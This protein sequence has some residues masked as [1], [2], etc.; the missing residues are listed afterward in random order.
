MP[1]PFER[2]RDRDSHIRNGFH[3]FLF[4]RVD[5]SWRMGS[6]SLRHHPIGKSCRISLERS[7]D[8]TGELLRNRQISS[9]CRSAKPA[10]A[11]SNCTACT[12]SAFCSGNSLNRIAP[13]FR[14]LRITAIGGVT[15]NV[16]HCAGATEIVVEQGGVLGFLSS[17]WSNR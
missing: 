16:P 11:M 12:E 8:P 15:V 14:K 17:R 4:S 13:L 6:T 3:I 9:R 1:V 5:L 10:T 7:E 2:L